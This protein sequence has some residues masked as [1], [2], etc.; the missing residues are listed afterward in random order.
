MQTSNL[1]FVPHFVLA[2][3]CCSICHAGEVVFPRCICKP[4]FCI[5][6]LDKPEKVKIAAQS[7][8][9]RK[10]LIRHVQNSNVYYRISLKRSF[11]QLNELNFRLNLA[12]FISKRTIQCDKFFGLF[13]IIIRPSISTLDR[14]RFLTIFRLQSQFEKSHENNP[15]LMR[16]RNCLQL[17]QFEKR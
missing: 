7:S 5:G 14:T 9:S 15:H 2:A 16:G 8:D 4:T 17:L 13:Y 12:I 1:H 6:V 10:K 11:F 3:F